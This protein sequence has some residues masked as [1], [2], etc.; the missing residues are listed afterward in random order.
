MTMRAYTSEWWIASKHDTRRGLWYREEGG[1][2]EI[3][4]GREGDDVHLMIRREDL[5]LGVFDALVSALDSARY[6]REIN[7]LHIL[8][9]ERR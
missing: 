3:C 5:P 7:G 4:A 1:V 6:A 8:T 2:L 9:G